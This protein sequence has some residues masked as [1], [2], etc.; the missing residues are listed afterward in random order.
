MGD[1]AGSEEIIGMKNKIAEGTNLAAGGTEEQSREYIRDEGLS[2]ADVEIIRE[3]DMIIVK[4]RRDFIYGE[5][6]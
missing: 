3:D 1:A 6:N 4:A 5:E 2:I